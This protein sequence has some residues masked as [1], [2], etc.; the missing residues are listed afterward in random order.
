MRSTPTHPVGCRVGVHREEADALELE[1]REGLRAA[2]T[3]VNH[4]LRYHCQR[5]RVNV[6]FP[7]ARHLR[8]VLRERV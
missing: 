6:R 3:R 8:L 5:G 2:H 4:C 7:A 1:L